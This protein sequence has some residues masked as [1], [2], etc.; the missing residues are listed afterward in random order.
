M[1]DQLNNLEE[2]LKSAFES[3]YIFPHETTLIGLQLKVERLCTLAPGNPPEVNLIRDGLRKVKVK[4]DGNVKNLEEVDK[5]KGYVIKLYGDMRRDMVS[6]YTKNLEN[7]PKPTEK[8]LPEKIEAVPIPEWKLLYE[9][10]R[11]RH[12]IEEKNMKEISPIWRKCAEDVERNGD[13]DGMG[14]TLMNMHDI[15]YRTE[16]SPDAKMVEVIKGSSELRTWKERL[17]ITLENVIKHYETS[18]GEI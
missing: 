17:D 11:L 9:L 12:Y 1:I 8:A 3:F 14:S 15:F 6:A 5:V 16:P 10:E 4:G 13:P 18:A 2:E 7:Q